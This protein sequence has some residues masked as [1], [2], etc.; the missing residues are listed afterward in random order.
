MKNLASIVVCH[1][2]ALGLDKA[3]DMVKGPTIISCVIKALCAWWQCL[4][5]LVAFLPSIVSIRWG[6]GITFLFGFSFYANAKG[7]D[8]PLNFE[9]TFYINEVSRISSTK[10]N[11]I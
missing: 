11:I 2:C 3:L 4:L 9:E 6:G 10:D 8:W 1:E 7:N 5:G